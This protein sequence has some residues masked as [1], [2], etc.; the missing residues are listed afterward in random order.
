MIFFFFFNISI[1]IIDQNICNLGFI[2]FKDL[3]KSE[4]K[5]N[6]IEKNFYLSERF[7]FAI[8]N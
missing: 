6:C 8:F 5:A 1:Q 4:T 7:F 2:Y 3:T